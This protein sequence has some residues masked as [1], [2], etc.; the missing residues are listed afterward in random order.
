MVKE[1]IRI[2]L[3]GGSTAGH[4]LPLIFVAR[5]LRNILKDSQRSF[6]IFYLGCKPLKTEVFMKEKID[7]YLLPTVKVRKYFDFKNV[8]DL[9]KLPFSFLL[10]FYYILKFMPN[11]VFS[12]GGP[13]SLEVVVAAWLLRIPVVIHDSDAIPGLSN[14]LASFFAKRITL[15]FESAADYFGRKKDKVLVVGQPID[16]NILKEPGLLSDYERFNLNPEEKIIL[17][18]GG[19]QGSKFLNDLIVKALPTL[20][21]LAQVV[22]ITGDKFYNEVYFYAK[23]LI[24]Q[25]NPTKMSRYHSYPYINHEDLMYL[26]KIVDLV[27]SRAGSGTI[28]ELAALGKPSILIPLDRKTAGLHQIKNAQIYSRYGG[29]EILEEENAQV[30]I[31]ITLI[32]DLLS[33]ESRLE[34]MH[35][36]A[37]SFAK[38]QAAQVIAKEL[39]EIMIKG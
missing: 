15:A 25:L 8:F 6:K 39:T 13:G 29:A 26:M 31:L 11:V 12:K 9:L 3:T 18:M 20:L 32:N 30:H 38:P 23:G 33:Q 21:N 5:E 1:E 35:Q 10:A 7:I 28:F 14:R 17:V 34:K 16:S 36:A 24:S 22:H 37:I 19:S 27:I 4:F 2:C